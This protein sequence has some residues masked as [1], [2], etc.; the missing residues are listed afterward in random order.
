MTDAFA[1][2]QWTETHTIDNIDDIHYPPN[3]LRFDAAE[4]SEKVINS[5]P[6]KEYREIE[7]CQ[8]SL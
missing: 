4:F 7:S 2:D 6:T 8:N 1:N 3:W 5:C